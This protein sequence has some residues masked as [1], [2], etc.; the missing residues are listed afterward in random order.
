MKL[1]KYSLFALMLIVISACNEKPKTTTTESKAS[2]EASSPTVQSVKN[3]ID[4]ANEMGKMDRTLQEM[5]KK[6]SDE[7]I[8]LEKIAKTE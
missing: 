7:V 2:V 1:V 5:A 6:I 8:E 3:K 4:A